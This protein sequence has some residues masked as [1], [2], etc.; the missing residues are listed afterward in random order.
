[1]ALNLPGRG[2]RLSDPLI[3][4]MAELVPHVVDALRAYF[5][6][7][8]AFF[9]HSVGAIVAYEVTRKLQQEQ[10]P[11]PLHLFVSAH[12]APHVAAHHMPMYDLSDAELAVLLRE[13]GFVPEEALE[14]E[15]LLS[16]IL[17]PL[18]ADFQLSETYGCD[19]P[20][21]LTV[22]ITALGGEA[23]TLVTKADLGDWKSYSTVAFDVKVF[24]GDHFYT[25]S[26]QADVIQMIVHTLEADVAALPKSM[27]HGEKAPYPDKCL[28][29]LFREQAAKMPGAIAVV[30]DDRSL[31]FGELDAQTDLLARYLW[32]RGVGVDSLVGIYMETS[33]A[34]V[35]AYLAALKAGGAYMPIEVA[36]PDA[37]LAQVLET[38]QPVV[39]LTNHKCYQRLP[40]VW[41]TRALPLDAGWME[42]LQAMTLEVPDDRPQ[43][44]LDTSAYC[45]MSSGTTGTPKGII[46]PHR[47]AVN[48]YAWRYV[49]HPYQ[50]GEREACNVFFVWEV[51]R[52]L[53]Q[54]YPTYIIPDEVIYDP[55]RLVAFL[56]EHR[57]TRVLFTPSLL[58]QI[59]NTPN[60]DLQTKLRHLRVVYLNGEVVTTALRNR[61]RDLLPQVT[62]LNDYSISECHDVCTYDLAELNPVLSA[63]YAP[64]GTPMTNV[65]I[66][67]LDEAL[68]PVPMGFQGEIY[69]GGDSVARGYLNEPQRTQERFIH[70]P[71]RNDSS[72]LFRTGDTGRILPNGHLEIQGRVAFMVKLRGYSIVPGAVE[73]TIAEHPAVNVAVVTTLDNEQTGQPEHLVAYV[74]GNGQVDD[75]TLVEQLRPY[76]RERL[77]PYA[78]PSYIMPLTALPLASIGK[79]DR[80]Q[81]PKPDPDASR[82]RRGVLT[83]PPATRLEQ[84]MATVWQDV[85]HTER[86]DVTEN[87]FDLGGHSLLA[88]ELCAR[89]REAIGL[90]VSVVDVFHYPTIRMLAQAYEPLTATSMPAAVPTPARPH[91]DTSI[92]VIGLACRFPGADDAEQ[93]WYNL[94]HGVCS[95]RPFSG[96]ALHQR[97]VP[98]GVYNRPG[99]I[100]AGATLDNVDQF[101]PA[102]WGISEREAVYMDP[103]H[104]LFLECCWH[105]LEH[106]GYAPSQNGARTGV[107]AGAFLPSYLLHC[108]HGGGLMDPGNPG[109]AHL[110]EIGNDKDYLATRVSHLLNL[111]G[112]SLSVQTSCSTGLVAVATACQ[113]LLAGQC[114]VALAGASSI[115]FPQAGYQYLEGFIYS[116]DGRC[117]AFDAEA[118]GTVL[119]DGVGV[120]VLKR[121]EDAE[122]A[123]DHIL[124]VIKG[125]AV[126]NDGNLKADYSAP[127]VQGQIE[128]VAAAQAMAGIDPETISYI[129]AHG[130]GTL[131]GDPIE[132]RALTSAFRQSTERTAFCALGSVKP[133]IGHSNIAAGVAGLIKVILSLHH[134]QLPPTINFTTPNPAMEL[135]SS[136]F[137][138]NDRLIEW[139][140]PEATPRRAGITCLGIGGTNC[141]MVLE[142]WLERAAPATETVPPDAP[143]STHHLLTLSA[144]T[145]SSLEQNRL[146]FIDYLQAQPTVNLGD[147]AYTLHVGREAF[148][149]RLAVVCHDA[150]S[151]VAQLRQTAEKAGNTNTTSGGRGTVVFMF[152]GQGSQ[153]LRMGWGLYQQLPAFRRYVDV[154]RD[155]LAPLIQEDLCG[156]LYAETE[157]PDLFSRAYILQ[158]ALFSVEYAMARLLMD[159]GIQ[160]HAVAGHSLG[161]Y[162]AACIAGIMSLEDALALVVTRGLAM[163]DA[164]AGA[165]LAVSLSEAGVQ[166]FL[167]QRGTHAFEDGPDVGLAAINAPRRVVLSGSCQAVEQAKKALQDAGV[168]C[169]RVHVLRA[170]HSSM[171]QQAADAVTRKARETTL[172]TPLIPLASNLTGAWLADSEAL[173]PTYWGHHMTQAV[174][175][176]ANIRT[177]LQQR[178]GALL[179]IGPGRI[180]S[181]L[182]TEI[183][184]HVPEFDPPLVLSTMRHPHET[185]MA[186]PHFLLN[187]LGR[188]WTAGIAMDWR[189][190]H[191]DV[192][193]Q[194]VPLPTYAFEG[195]RCW[196][197]HAV[198][199]PHLNGLV[200]KPPATDGKLPLAERFYLPS[201]QRTLPPP[202]PSLTS[203]TRWLVFL[204][205]AGIAGALG[206]VLA[207]RLEQQGHRVQ[208]VYRAGDL[209]APGDQP[210]EMK[211]A[212]H[213]IH[214]TQ[215]EAYAALLQQLAADGAYPQR[216]VYLWGLEGA[217]GS[218]QQALLDTY[219]PFLHLAQALMAQVAQEPLMLWV[220]TDKSVQVN[221]ESLQPVKATMFG[222]S[223]VLSQEN[224]QVRC[225]LVDVQ[226]PSEIA[227]L[228]RLAETVLHECMAQRPDVEPLV[229]LRGEHRWRPQYEAVRLEPSANGA[230]AGM[231]QPHKTYIIT[232]G[233]G[234]IGL[235]LAEHLAILPCKLVLTTRAAF[236]DR[237]R[238]EAIAASS[239]VA[240]QLQETVQR[241]L[242]CEAAGADLRV[243]QADM[244]KASDVRRMLTDT[245]HRFGEISGI[246]HAAG[247]AKL[248][249]LPNLTPEISEQ[250]FGGKLYGVLHLEQAI[251][252]LPCKPEFV[253]LFSSMAAILGGLAMSAY[254]AANRF[255]DAFVQANPRRHG[256]AWLSINWDDWDFVYDQEQVLAYE[257]TQARFAMTPAEGIASLERILAY[258]R[259]MQLLVV[260][261]ALHPRVTQWL[262]QKPL[263]AL[264]SEHGSEA[265]DA[266]PLAMEVT[267]DGHHFEQ[268]IAAIYR[269]V[270]GLSE[271]AADDNFFDLGG[272]SLLASQV[273]MQLRCQL[274][275]V[276]IQLP[277]IFDYPTVR[278]MAQY[279]AESHAE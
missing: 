41:R 210:D 96:E 219:Y 61:F 92:A 253:V 207:T 107:F 85:L 76:L 212:A 244:A 252:Q 6:K 274:P 272:D 267:G 184:L 270:L 127:S 245:L 116:R 241:L 180:L 113:A 167:Q 20:S 37:H 91:T 157:H 254:A 10:F 146:K 198:H 100:N 250:E 160:P 95:I 246:F 28:H 257:K 123:G 125:F 80:R 176:E 79:L 21:P 179:E 12:H 39:V 153:Y 5:D 82:S 8:F 60:L 4:D 148:A 265:S 161:E 66:Y 98:A 166:D 204:P 268:P 124:A 132:V 30:G 19:T 144:K 159:W 34:F 81:L 46:C 248:R 142:E 218:A 33:V 168:A 84:T 114:D 147:V 73:T 89:L 240:P 229:A 71:I 235:V 115:T 104:R 32:H 165:M 47:G 131:I 87:F 72:T 189:A 213:A 231:V 164:G 117:R 49:H 90:Q 225:R 196:P 278:E 55:P 128:V 242:K 70:D 273:L 275:Q 191:A 109:L 243:I 97:G 11:L 43:P 202:C 150:P 216:I 251:G 88:A 276:Q 149:H 156:L 172:R 119:G 24:D 3:T 16:L 9:G 136:P 143:V 126:N 222:T 118:S 45:V 151:A 35:I 226:L 101:D 230:A 188:L 86:V 17:P 271:V 262:H 205:G 215:A 141:H 53:L 22:P 25:R 103:Q 197:D 192:R 50:A 194:R 162:V 154:C 134:R 78:V 178:P 69:V 138:V 65:Y 67:L 200:A 68:Q 26:C 135:E 152:S 220:I 228:S 239:D 130:T 169:Q 133:N 249:Y 129:E 227:L 175:F 40:A 44:T 52:P 209:P 38:A 56:S 64:L 140:V 29:E 255:M 112:P 108:L 170:F 36:Y 145:T 203:E 201:W 62:L 279:L 263:S 74:V 155:I 195:H 58:E 14:N 238:W 256:V 266:A 2:S 105:A 183:S 158:P 221:D 63:K 48:S 247:F 120:V 15:G 199:A 173:D 1:M 261:R 217:E 77:P 187:T 232:G 181:G 59:L 31:T 182:A 18:K 7:P 211:R 75:D 236:P 233:L 264:R 214:A 193:H 139:T 186:D 23:D 57:I 54:G 94:R 277:V 234:R 99:Y 224:P 185:A 110:T 174:R 93:F 208:R 258:G 42:P 259:P 171:M 163:E 177:I 51:I 260:T 83:A 269:E 102:F 111:R 206:D 223:L 121:L 122:A 27:L 13:L 137:F 237:S 190:F 106:A